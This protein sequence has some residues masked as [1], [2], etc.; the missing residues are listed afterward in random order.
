MLYPG[1]LFGWEAYP[2]AEMQSMYS[3][4]PADWSVFPSYAEEKKFMSLECSAIKE[5]YFAF[6]LLLL[7]LLLNK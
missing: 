3:T 1:H 6:Y 7:Y 2:Y 4:V 5:K